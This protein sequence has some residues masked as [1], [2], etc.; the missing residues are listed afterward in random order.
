M[1]SSRNVVAAAAAASPPPQL[2]QQTLD[3]C[4]S[5]VQVRAAS[6]AADAHDNPTTPS[7]IPSTDPHIL[8]PSLQLLVHM[9]TVDGAL[10]RRVL[11]AGELKGHISHL[12][13]LTLTL[14]ARHP[15]TLA[16]MEASPGGAAAS[17]AAAADGA[18]A[19]SMRAMLHDVLLLLGLFAHSSRANAE[20]LRWKWGEEPALL[21]RLCA[22]PFAYFC[23]PHLRRVLLPT[24]LCGCL[25]DDI[26]ARI[27][28]ARLNPLHLVAFLRAAADAAAA[29]E[30]SPGGA[31]AAAAAPAATL[32]ADPSELP[33]V[34]MDFTLAARLPP[35][36]WE[37][38]IN[39]FSNRPVSPPADDADDLATDSPA[40]APAAAGGGRVV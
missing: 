26:N 13:H 19:A 24:L 29:M 9:A 6:L 28:A 16:A 40:A 1:G 18:A 35:A 33:V 10:V 11:G 22:L 4:R 7:H 38:A 20:V 17:V 23:E 31:P 27:L 36:Q 37:A 5:A 2:S 3:V 30:N 39:Y 12:A 14:A 25:R 15:G 21:H 8:L 32:T 34:A